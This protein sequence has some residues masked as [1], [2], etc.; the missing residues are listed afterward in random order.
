MLTDSCSEI[1]ANPFIPDLQAHTWQMTA[2]VS[3]AR[4]D[5]DL[6]FL[7]RCVRRCVRTTL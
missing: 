3:D 2:V 5:A 7:Y 6:T 1:I 4:D